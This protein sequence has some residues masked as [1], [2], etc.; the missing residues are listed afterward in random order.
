MNAPDTYHDLL[1]E[2]ASESLWQDDLAASPQFIH[3]F[4]DSRAYLEDMLPTALKAMDR[5][6]MIWVSWPK[7]ASKVPTDVVEDTIRA[8]CLPLGLVDVKVC[9]VD[10]IWSGLKLMIRKELR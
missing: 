8:L 6:G 7:K 2:L 9:A 4:T 10:E 1:G 5:N 3:M